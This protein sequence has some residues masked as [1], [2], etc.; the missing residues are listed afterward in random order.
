MKIDDD[1]AWKDRIPE[2]RKLIV[3]YSGDDVEMRRLEV[4]KHDDDISSLWSIAEGKD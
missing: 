3:S 1:A 2:C 4:W